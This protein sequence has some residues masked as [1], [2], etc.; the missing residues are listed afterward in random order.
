MTNIKRLLTILLDV[1]LL[2]PSAI[3]AQKAGP[4]RPK[5][6][7]GAAALPAIKITDYP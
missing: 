2:A 4:G 7:S 5:A 3:L 1:E 6:G